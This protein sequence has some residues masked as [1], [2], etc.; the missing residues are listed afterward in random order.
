MYLGAGRTSARLTPDPS[1]GVLNSVVR[2]GHRNPH[3][4]RRVSLKGGGRKNYLRLLV[5]FIGLSAPVLLGLDDEPG[6]TDDLFAV[7]DLEHQPRHLV[8]NSSRIGDPCIDIDS[9]LAVDDRLDLH[10]DPGLPRII[11]HVVAVSDGKPVTGE[12]SER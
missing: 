9:D 12:P 2:R 3:S 5:G 6:S 8:V 4:C 11:L 1:Q 7:H 10:Y